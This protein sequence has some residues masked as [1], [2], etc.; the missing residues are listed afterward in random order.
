MTLDTLMSVA[1]QILFVVFVVWLAAEALGIISRM[2]RRAFVS[3]DSVSPVTLSEKAELQIHTG[4][5]FGKSIL[6]LALGAKKIVGVGQKALGE[7]K[8]VAVKFVTKEGE[9]KEEPKIVKINF[10]GK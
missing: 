2:W 9:P 1:G 6:F 8:D 4:R 7:A 3:V 5:P 10:F